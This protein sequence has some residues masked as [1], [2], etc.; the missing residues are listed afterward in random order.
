[1]TYPTM[2]FPSISA[3]YGLAPESTMIVPVEYFDD[4]G[5]CQHLEFPL[6]FDKPVLIDFGRKLTGW[7]WLALDGEAEYIYGADPEQILRM[8]EKRGDSAFCYQSHPSFIGAKPV[9]TVKSSGG[10]VILDENLSALRLLWLKPTSGKV[11]LKHCRLEFSAPHLPLAGA[12]QCDD[13]ELNKAWQIGVYTNLLCTQN[14][15]DAMIPTPAP[16]SGYVMWDGA[17]RDREVWAGDLRLSS[18]VWLAAYEDPEPVRNS[19]FML[20]QARHLNCNETGLIPG[21]AATHQTF[22]EWTFWYLVNLWEYYQWTGDKQLLRA[23]MPMW[24][25]LDLT[26]E[27]IKRNVNGNGI[28]E[29]TNSWM[30]VYKLSGEMAALAIVQVAGLE[31]LAKLFIVCGRE[32]LAAQASELAKRTR[33]VIPQRFYD[34]Q[35]RA[36]RMLSLDQQ[37]PAH[38]PLDAN[39]WAVL[40]G[41]GDPEMQQACLDFLQH[42]GLESD[43]GLRCLFPVFD[44]KDGDW[45][46]YNPNWHWVHNTTVWPYPN[47]YAAWARF[48]AGLD[49]LALETLKRI[50]RPL[51]GRGHSTAWEAMMPDGGLPFGPDGNTLSFCH[52]W[53]GA[54]SYLLQHRALGIEALAPGFAEV[55]INPQLG[56]LKHAAGKVPTPRGT[57]EVE[58]ENSS[59]GIRGKII[60]PAGVELSEG[61][62]GVDVISK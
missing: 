43:A 61:P 50:H 28:I 6:A 38:Y 11:T 4:Q 3:E 20:W 31:A 15:M 17:R 13:E 33:A 53:S 39:A 1:M 5:H 24:G 7:V 40:Y 62:R 54:G 25:G 27:W 19:L 46:G 8:R 51:I 16:G 26:L 49:D 56:S 57:I 37:K 12:F 48:E 14:N 59:G 41:I 2:K 34:P 23:L 21:S 30:Y 36:L 47:V 32:D 55:A 22:Y 9:G 35:A 42:P 10:D 44:D 45:V 18:L 58:Y 52:A 60:L 29:A